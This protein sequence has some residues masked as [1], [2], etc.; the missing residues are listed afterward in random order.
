MR[1]RENNMIWD[2]PAC[3]LCSDLMR[4]FVL[5]ATAAGL[6]PDLAGGHIWIESLAIIE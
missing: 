2:I 3:W 5:L 6:W 4:G 1:E